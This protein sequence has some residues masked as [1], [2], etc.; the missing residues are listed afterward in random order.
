[1]IFTT[2]ASDTV[3]EL[4]LRIKQEHNFPLE[5]QILLFAN[6]MLDN[7][8]TLDSYEVMNGSTLILIVRH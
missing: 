3:I 6:K 1:M 8:Q 5:G 4:K 2:P 7:S